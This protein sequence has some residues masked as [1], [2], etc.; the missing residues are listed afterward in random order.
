MPGSA[1]DITRRSVLATLAAPVLTGKPS[2]GPAIAATKAGKL[3]GVIDNDV[4]VFKGIPYGEDTAP[5]R[6]MAPVPAKPWTGIRDALK[7][8]PRA[9]QPAGRLPGASDP[10]SEDCLTLNVWTPGMRDGGKRAVMVWHHGAAIRPVR[11]TPRSPT[12]LVSAGAATWWW[13]ASITG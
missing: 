11:R 5:R 8:G 12:A 1:F 10:V 13:S 4:H 6:F 9:P 2:G 3:R 7:Y